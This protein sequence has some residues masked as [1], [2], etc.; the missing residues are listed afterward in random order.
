MASRGA[1]DN[2]A[3]AKQLLHELTYLLS[4]ITQAA[5]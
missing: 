4:A 1:F 5:S 3:A 2:D